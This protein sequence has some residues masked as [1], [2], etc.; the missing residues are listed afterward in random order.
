[1][2]VLLTACANVGQVQGECEAIYS[3]FKDI[4]NC[5]KPK[6]LET[7]KHSKDYQLLKLY[8]LEGEVLSEQI[9]KGE[10]S[11]IEAKAKWQK[12]Y[13]DLGAKRRDAP[14]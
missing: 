5:S 9:D 4:Y 1:L 2:T 8:L 14:N 3:K 12:L 6:L 10:I 13:L 7:F 11:D